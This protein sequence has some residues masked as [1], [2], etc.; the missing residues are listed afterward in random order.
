MAAGDGI[1]AGDP[2]GSGDIRTVWPIIKGAG[3]GG[4]GCAGVVGVC[5]IERGNGDGLSEGSG[6]CV[7]CFVIPSKST[8]AEGKAPEG[9][10]VTTGCDVTGGGAAG[11]GLGRTG[12][13]VDDKGDGGGDPV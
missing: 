10:G 6:G 12:G 9:G 7:N 5:C 4:D 2:A 13:C 3:S 11:V 1:G 8:G